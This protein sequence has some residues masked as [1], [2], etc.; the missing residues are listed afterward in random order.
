MKPT[1]ITILANL[2]GTDAEDIKQGL[3]GSDVLALG[4]EEWLVTECPDGSVSIVQVRYA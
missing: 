1:T 2:F 3:G 4:R